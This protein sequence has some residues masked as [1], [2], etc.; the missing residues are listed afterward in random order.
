MGKSRVAA[1]IQ[2]RMGSSRL[3]GK[4]LM[5]LVGKPVLWHIIHRLR[6]CRTV[7]LIAIATSDRPND[8]ALVEFANHEDIPLIRGPEDNVLL[9]YAKATEE[10]DPDVIV[11]VTGDAPLIDPGTVDKLVEKLLQEKAEY[12]SGEKG[13]DTIHEEFDPFSRVGLNRLLAEAAEDPVAIEHVTAYFSVHL[14]N[15]H[16][17]YV[18]ISPKHHFKGTRMSVD[19]PADLRFIEQLYHYLDVPAGEAD[20]CCGKK[21]YYGKCLTVHGN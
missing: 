4:V 8:D 19:T 2:A 12:C 16:I 5:P 15:F 18:P 1:I 9:R 3:P 13:V 20:I 7:D 11:R 21:A 10:L 14:D 17:A 6:K